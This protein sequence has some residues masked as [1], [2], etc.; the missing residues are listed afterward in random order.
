L[1][2]RGGERGGMK[3]GGGVGEG[4]RGR[5]QTFL[6]LTGVTMCHL[7]T[8]N[9]NRVFHLHTYKRDLLYSKRDL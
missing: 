5:E 3:G 7:G 1:K 9:V 6:A 8:R 4:G 2:E